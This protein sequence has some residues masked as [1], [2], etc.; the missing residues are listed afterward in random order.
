MVCKV[1]VFGTLGQVRAVAIGLVVQ[2]KA[3]DCKALLL[4]FI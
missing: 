3:V 1:S 2:C 4:P